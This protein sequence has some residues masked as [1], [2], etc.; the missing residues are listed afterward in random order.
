MHYLVTAVSVQPHRLKFLS[1]V[2]GED[3]SACPVT[4]HPAGPGKAA[5]AGAGKPGKFF[6]SSPH[7]P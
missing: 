3:F 5:Q 2:T 6:L 4:R 1:G 7:A